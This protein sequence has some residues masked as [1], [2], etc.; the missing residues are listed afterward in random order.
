MR[1]PIGAEGRA[2]PGSELPPVAQAPGRWARL[3]LRV[4]AGRRRR[5]LEAAVPE[6]LDVLRATVGAGAAPGHGLAAAADAAGEP[7]AG[8]LAGAVAAHAAGAP[9]GQA[10]AD[11]GRRA[12][13]PELAL[14]GEAL[15]LAGRTGAPPARVLAGVASAAADRVRARQAL[16]AATAEARLSAR[17]I[18]GLGPAFLLVLA[19]VAPAEASFLFTEPAGWVALALAAGLEAAGLAW[20]SRILRVPR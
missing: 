4:G 20:S 5:A 8:V 13:L 19:L 10:L 15:E 14:A 17:V 7:L 2:W 12:C 11:A 6:V 18:A 9:A 16:S 3:A 1:T